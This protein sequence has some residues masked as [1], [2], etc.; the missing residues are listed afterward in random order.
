[1]AKIADK[2]SEEHYFRHNS[3]AFNVSDSSKFIK[4]GSLKMQEP[5]FNNLQIRLYG[6]HKYNCFVFLQATFLL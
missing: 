1:M 4:K 5:I 6:D 3:L 2:N